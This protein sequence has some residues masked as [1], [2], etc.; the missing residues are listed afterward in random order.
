MSPDFLLQQ[1]EEEKMKLHENQLKLIRH[2]IRFNSLDYNTCLEIL[3]TENTGDRIAMSYAFRPLT[4][5]KYISKNKKDVVSILSKGKKLFPK[6]KPLISEGGNEQSKKRTLQVSRMASLMERCEVIISGKLPESQNP[7][8]IPSACWRNIAPGILSTTR[9][10]GMLLAYGKKYAVYDIGDGS[11][12]WQVRAE[13]SLFYTRYGSYETKADGMIL[14]CD[15]DKKRKIAENI[16]RYTMWNRKSLLNANYTE[17]N[18]PVRYSRSPIKL[19]TQYEHVYI[20][21]PNELKHDLIKIYDEDRIIRNI[22]GDNTRMIDPKQGDFEDWP[23]R[24]YISP[25]FDL[26]KLV[27]FFSAVKTHIELDN[28]P[29]PTHVPKITYAIIM[30]RKDLPIIKM[31]DDVLHSEKVVMYGFKSDENT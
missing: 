25:A 4:K 1:K 10:T 20:T 14:V 28:S 3:D 18:K 7:H 21:T 13:S 23:K 27:Y 22:A 9:F 29:I 2:L 12:E 5:N 16:I 17:R 6:E 8:F 19:R 15:N 26:L 24:F 30:P 11:V 31:Y